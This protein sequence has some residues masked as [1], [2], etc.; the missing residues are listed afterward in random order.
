MSSAE[1]AGV[2]QSVALEYDYSYEYG[3]TAVEDGGESG[4]GIGTHV[5]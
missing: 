2:E 4:V 5:M 3:N 1:G